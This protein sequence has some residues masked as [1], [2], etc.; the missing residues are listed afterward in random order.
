M[1]RR[2]AFAI[3]WRSLGRANPRFHAILPICDVRASWPRAAMANGCTTKSLCRQM[4]AQ[5]ESFAKRSQLLGKRKR[6]RWT[7]HVSEKPAVLLREFQRSRGRRCR[8]RL[9]RAAALHAELTRTGRVAFRV[10]ARAIL[11]V[12][13]E[14]SSTRQLHRGKHPER[15]CP[16]IDLPASP[17]ERPG[18]RR[19][20]QSSRTDGSKTPYPALSPWGGDRGPNGR[21]AQRAG[22]RGVERGVRS[23]GRNPRNASPNP[24]RPGG[25]AEL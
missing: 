10:P 14:L 21:V 20:Q 11:R 6:C 9:K 1:A 4:P 19:S 13:S 3:L 12:S 5:P 16:F 2:C 22:V 17:S 7:W 23:S 18:L 24:L 15:Q 25:P 8:F